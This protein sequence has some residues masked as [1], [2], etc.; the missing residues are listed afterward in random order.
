MCNLQRL[1]F[2]TGTARTFPSWSRWTTTSSCSWTS[3]S[4]CC[5]QS[6]TIHGGRPQQPPLSHCHCQT[7][8]TH[9]YKRQLGRPICW[10]LP[11][12]DLPAQEPHRGQ[13]CERVEAGPQQRVQV[14]HPGGAVPRGRLPDLRHGA[15]LRR[16]QGRHIYNSKPWFEE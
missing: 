12:E 13:H 4:G 10:S 9:Q 7:H 8:A 11:Q 14:L 2:A 3:S 5:A 1:P 15:Q 16:L 6:G